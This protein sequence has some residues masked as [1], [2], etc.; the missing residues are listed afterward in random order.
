MKTW[1][2]LAFVTV[3]VLVAVFVGCENDD[4]RKDRKDPS[5]PALVGTAYPYA[6]GSYYHTYWNDRTGDYYIVLTDVD[7][8]TGEFSNSR[9]DLDLLA[10]PA[11]D[12]YNTRLPDGTYT[13]G[14]SDGGP[15]TLIQGYV[16]T[17]STGGI[18]MR[19]SYWSEEDP[20]DPSAL[21]SYAFASGYVTVSTN[22]GV[23]TVE[24]ALVDEND[25]QKDFYYQGTLDYVN[26]ANDEYTGFS[27][28]R[29]D[30]SFKSEGSYAT[31]KCLESHDDYD[32]WQL[33]VYEKEC[34]E[35]QGATGYYIWFYLVLESGLDAVP[36]GRYSISASSEKPSGVIAGDY[37]ENSYGYK[38]LYTWLYKGRTPYAPISGGE[39]VIDRD[40][41]GV[42]NIR[43]VMEDDHLMPYRITGSYRGKF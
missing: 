31:M 10:E 3:L 29:D 14:S 34:Y 19:G 42:Y 37:I 12:P 28:L 13:I 15:G 21:R 2:L 40:E 22:G 36:P 17:G 16:D 25:Q 39:L 26:R 24:G 32:I 8:D 33:P 1:R 35:T 7:L 38:A 23:T 20:D 9:I 4:G 27:Q 30:L 43:F 18:I 41:S 11:L 6:Y 5:E